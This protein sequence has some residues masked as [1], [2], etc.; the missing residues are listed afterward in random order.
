MTLPGGASGKIGIRYE[1]LWTVFC[2]IRVMQEEAEWIWLERA[3]EENEGFEFALGTPTGVEYH[4]VKRQRTGMGKWSLSILSSEGVLT[5]FYQKLDD[6]SVT[7]V[8][9]SAHAADV[10]EELANR[11]RSANSWLE[12][13]Q[14]FI[15][16]DGGSTEF[17]SLHNRWNASDKEVSF[18]RLRRAYV[19][20]ID[21][22]LLRK[23]VSSRLEVLVSGNPENVLDVLFKQGL[24]ALYQR[25]D[26]Q[27]IRRHLTS[28]G[29]SKQ[30]WATDPMVADKI[31]ELNQAYLAGIKP[32]GIGGEVIHRDEA[33]EILAHFNAEGAKNVALLT[34]PAGVGKA[35]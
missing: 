12:F 23:L 25:L 14:A 29:F 3:G 32:I 16:S 35:R 8:F 1:G 13:N 11:A 7:C 24:D 17:S 31:E 15:S 4:Q 20:T 28:R 26:S 5:N 27:Q 19:H 21:E 22:D 30:T 33:D 2:M 34:G 10:L 9:V 6:P 18:Q